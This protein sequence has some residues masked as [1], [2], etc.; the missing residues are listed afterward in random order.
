MASAILSGT[1]MSITSPIA[2]CLCSL[3]ISSRTHTPRT[4]QSLAS[5][6]LAILRS[7]Y[8]A[9]SEPR[10]VAWTTSAGTTAGGGK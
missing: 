1:A 6:I 3:P 9:L 7:G 2:T 5:F 4:N 8:A 10:C